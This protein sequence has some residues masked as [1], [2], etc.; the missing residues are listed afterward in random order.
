M[1]FLFRQEEPFPVSCDLR[2]GMATRAERAATRSGLDLKE[3][4]E[5]TDKKGAHQRRKWVT[6]IEQVQKYREWCF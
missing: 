6:V 5:D 3:L 1:Y 4:Q 2:D